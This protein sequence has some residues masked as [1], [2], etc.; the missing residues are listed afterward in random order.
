MRIAIA[1]DAWMPQVNGVVRTLTNTISRLV[2]RG[3]EVEVIVPHDFVTVPLPGYREIRMAIA[4][5]GGVR[6]TLDA[7]RPDIVHVV[8]EGPIGWCAR[9][10]CL[11]HEVPLTSAFH[12]RFP[13]YLAMRTGV[14]PEW[15]WPLMRRFHAPARTIFVSTD[16][17]GAELAERGLPQGRIW[18]RGIDAAVFHPD[19]KLHPALAALP[20]PIA[21]S[22]GR[23][24]VEKNI[25]AFL[26]AAWRGSKVVVGD[27]PALASLRQRH[28]DV[29]FLGA[30]HGSDLAQA[31]ASAD[32]FVFPSHTDTFGLVMIEALACGLPVAAYPVSGPI[33]IIGADGRGPRGDLAG[34]VG[35]LDHD[36]ATAMN[37][38]LHADRSV[39]CSHGQSF[40]W[41]RCTDQFVAG[42]TES[43]GRSLPDRVT[44]R[45][46]A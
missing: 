44:D 30:L 28:P 41:D 36:L 7:F 37:R 23:V 22:V 18:S 9:G 14:S 19:Q 25:E 42:L 3:Y 38:A 4:P 20:R 2:A 21:L 40:N 12:T 26:D 13:D 24:A 34:L 10:W 39:A 45:I 32:L 6:R 1:T 15:F 27:G 35:A 43:S 31:Y 16:G 11:T 29:L 46:H 17:L 33:D 8:T 5:R